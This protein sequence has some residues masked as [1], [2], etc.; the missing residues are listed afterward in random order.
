MTLSF[1]HVI[2]VDIEHVLKMH[3]D[4]QQHCKQNKPVSVS[5]SVLAVGVDSNVALSTFKENTL[6]GIFEKLGLFH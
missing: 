4:A 2:H 6:L 5:H 1:A 3:M